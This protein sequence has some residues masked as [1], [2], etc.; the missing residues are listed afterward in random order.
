MAVGS[1]SILDMIGERT[2]R[3]ECEL[4]KEEMDDGEEK[5]ARREERERRDG[6]EEG[7]TE[8]KQATHEIKRVVD[9]GDHVSLAAYYW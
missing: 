5:K 2:I 1:R 8:R 4:E 9:R 6:R 7:E 3:D